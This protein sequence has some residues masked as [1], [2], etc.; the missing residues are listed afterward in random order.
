MANGVDAE[1]SRGDALELDFDLDEVFFGAAWL[2]RLSELS[3][4][5]FKAPVVDEDSLVR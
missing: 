2:K 5:K 1:D 3:K 4:A